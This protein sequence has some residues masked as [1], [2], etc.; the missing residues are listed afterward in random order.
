MN[1]SRFELLLC[2]LL[3]Y[4]VREPA[5][6]AKSLVKRYGDASALAAAD[7]E[8]LSCMEHVGPAGAHIVRL[9][10][11]LR[12]RRVTDE[13]VLP[14]YFTESEF[15]D[16]ITALF[17]DSPNERI[18]AFL[19]DER[20][21]VAFSELLGEGTVNS[22]SILPRKLLEA[23]VRRGCRRVI[24]AHNHPSGRAVASREDIEATEQIAL[25]LRESQRELI[26]HYVV[27]GTDVCKI[28]K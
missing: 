8:E 24:L 25:V 14:R 17:F 10:Y 23:S 12:S 26:A 28:T 19:V 13:F 7:Y 11:A 27:A 1:K 5:L 16:Y 2:K 3:S 22:M 6:A 15:Q 20:G 18:Y 21:R 9:A 4:S